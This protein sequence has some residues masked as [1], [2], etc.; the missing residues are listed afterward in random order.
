MATT[1]RMSYATVEADPV[2][3]NPNRKEEV[4]QVRAR[5]AIDL[6]GIAPRAPNLSNGATQFPA[7][8]MG[9]IAYSN[10]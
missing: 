9:G 6:A 5:S 10:T 1:N 3:L 2:T 8:M 7:L 4:V